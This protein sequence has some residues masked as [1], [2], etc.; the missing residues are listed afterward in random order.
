MTMQMLY[1]EEGNVTCQYSEVND[2]FMWGDGYL[3][4]KCDQAEFALRSQLLHHELECLLQ[5]R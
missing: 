1:V 3:M 2:S 5:Q 4:V